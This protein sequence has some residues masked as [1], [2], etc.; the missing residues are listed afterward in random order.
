M[1]V[2]KYIFDKNSYL[3][4]PL[5]GEAM[6]AKVRGASSVMIKHFIRK[7]CCAKASSGTPFH[8]NSCEMN[9]IKELEVRVLD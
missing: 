9:R 6:F 2:L 3:P 5:A 1:S 4:L 8:D 7:L